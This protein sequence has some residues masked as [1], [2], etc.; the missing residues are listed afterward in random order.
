MSFHSSNRDDL[1]SAQKRLETILRT[2][3]E[4]D[5]GANLGGRLPTTWFSAKIDGLAPNDHLKK[6]Q[7]AVVA[8][9]NFLQTQRKTLKRG[10]PVGDEKL[11]RALEELERFGRQY[12]RNVTVDAVD[13]WQILGNDVLQFDEALEHINL[14]R[15]T[16]LIHAA[17]S[18]VGRSVE[19]KR[20]QGLVNAR[21]W[22]NLDPLF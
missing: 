1:R 16:F 20:I 8:A 14:V 15:D 21:A 3:K 9:S 7:L 11:L 18:L 4:F 13:F 10:R 17:S 19:F 2:I 22:K 6:A 5:E 12:L